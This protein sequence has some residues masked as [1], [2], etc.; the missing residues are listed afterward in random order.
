MNPSL[1]V[2]PPQAQWAAAHEYMLARGL[3]C[4]SF[5][6]GFEASY[7]VAGAGKWAPIA[8]S[9]TGAQ[10]PD[11][12]Y[13]IHVHGPCPRTRRAQGALAVVSGE[14]VDL[15]VADGTPWIFRGSHHAVA[16]LRDS[17]QVAFRLEEWIAN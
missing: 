10:Q 9:L 15:P 1:F 2:D 14:Y 5:S 7:I 11:G 17:E 6:P 12:S 4:V 16:C 13:S 8:G 3:E